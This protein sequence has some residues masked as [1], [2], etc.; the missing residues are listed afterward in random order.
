MRPALQARPEPVLLHATTTPSWGAIAHR[1]IAGHDD[2]IVCRLPEEADPQFT[3]STAD[4]GE[5]EERMDAS[6]P[7]LSAAAGLLLTIELFRLQHGLILER[8]SNYTGLNLETPVPL[9]TEYPWR[10]RAGCHVRFLLRH[11]CD[12]LP[13]REGPLSMPQEP[14]SRSS[15]TMSLMCTEACMIPITP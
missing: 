3:C 2:C 11:V 7:F 1:H 5:G 15:E 4:V 10:C 12:V 6:L 8:T 9:V 14:H 13:A